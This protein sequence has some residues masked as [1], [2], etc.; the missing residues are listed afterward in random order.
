MKDQ[1][2]LT[3]AWLYIDNIYTIK[4]KNIIKGTTTAPTP[5]P[6]SGEMASHSQKSLL[7]F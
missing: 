4:A 3:F 5:P 1:N 7:S 2:L 6:P